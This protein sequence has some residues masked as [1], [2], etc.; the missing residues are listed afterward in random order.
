M[1]PGP[2]VLGRKNKIA[3]LIEQQSGGLVNVSHRV[4][5]S[6]KGQRSILTW[7]VKLPVP[8]QVSVSLPPLP[9]LIVWSFSSTELPPE[10]LVTT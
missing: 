7:H 3:K 1:P 9:D 8:M 10:P 6:H 4:D 5:L 2:S